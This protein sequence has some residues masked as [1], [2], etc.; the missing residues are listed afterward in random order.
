MNTPYWL[1][2]SIF[3]QIFP[4]RFANGD[5]NNDPTNIQKWGST[6]TIWGFQG[7]DLRGIINHFDY[8]LDLGVNALYLTP[9]F[10]ASST[11]RYNTSDYFLIDPK[12]GTLADF[13][14]LINI[15]HG[16]GLRIILDGVFNH[17][18][19]GFFAFSDVL[20]NGEHSPYKDW[21][22]IR[23]FPLEAYGTGDSQ[24][25]LGW[26]NHKSLP[27]LNTSNPQV[28]KYIYSVA[29]YWLEQGI[30]G[31]RLDVPN[32]I[33]DDG[34]WAE[35]RHVVRNVNRDACLIGEIWD[36][37]PRWANNSHFDGLMNYPVKDALVGL[38]QDRINIHIFRERIQAIISAYSR[39]NLFAMYVPLDSHDTERFA[40]LM[41]GNIEKVKLAYLF[42][43]AFPGAPAIY[44]GDEIGLE[45]GKDPDN[46]RAFPWKEANWNHDLRTWIKNLIAV[47]KKTPS[48]RRGDFIEVQIT[49][50]GYVF[51]RILGEDKVMAVLNPSSHVCRFDIDCSKLGWEGE[52]VVHE[53]T[54]WKKHTLTNGHLS[55]TVPA[56]SG[57]LLA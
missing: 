42:L 4:D 29:R 16:N 34:F 55:V 32:E 56:W 20:E 12:L 17:C 57:I 48:L 46:R 38:L 8:L 36:I 37:N 51:A 35:Y 43:M 44:Y 30:D 5:Q 19:R 53:L 40:T 50:E 45:G 15:V 24:N 11:H 28:R 1:Q 41:N 13:Q 23:R 27:K 9:I 47:R 7:G 22:H 18:G 2:D 21:F 10:A 26:W 25:Y 52:R 49:D 54:E 3:Y 33:D 6:P 14:A 39:E 31:W